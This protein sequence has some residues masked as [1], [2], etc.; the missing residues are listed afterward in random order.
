MRHQTIRMETK[1]DP[2]LESVKH[3]NLTCNG[4]SLELGSRT[5]IMGVLNITPDSFSDGGRFYAL[6]KAV[7]RAEA[8]AA[9][10]ADIIDIGGESTRPFSDPVPADEELRRVIPVIEKIAGRVE[11][12]ISI[13]T[14][15]ALV[16]RRAIDAGADIINDISSM[17]ADPAIGGVAAETQAPLILM[18][19]QGRPKTMQQDP[20]YD[21]LMGEVIG[22]LKAAIDRATRAGVRRNRIIIDPGIG[23]GKT[24]QHNLSLINRLPDL[25]ALDAPILIGPSRKAFIRHLLKTSPE[26]ELAPDHPHVGIGTQAVVAAAILNGAH[27]VRVH[28]VAQTRLTV[29]MIDAIRHETP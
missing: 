7:A 11:A 5:V 29:R 10:G 24:F 23:F 6:E 15:K 16:A 8:L 20:H 17:N 21:D 18:H 2:N 1:P 28:D 26:D 13:D 3:F 4:R 9:E 22:F 14:T 19:M 12:L 25:K 27:L